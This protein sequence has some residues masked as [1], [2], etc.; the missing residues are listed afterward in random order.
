MQPISIIIKVFGLMAGLLLSL[1]P[2]FS[3]FPVQAE[4]LEIPGTGACEVLL[5]AVAQAFTAKY[6]GHQVLIPPSTGT[7]GGIRAVKQDRAVLGRVAQPSQ[8]DQTT[9]G[10][11]YLVFAQDMVIFAVG[12]KV[13]VRNLT[14]AQLV[15]VYTGKITDWREVGGEPGPIRVLARQPGDS[16]LKIIEENLPLFRKIVYTSSAKVAHTDPKMLEMLQKYKYSIGWLTFSG[17]K[18]VQTPL[19]PLALDG[20][21]P[22]PENVRSHKYKLVGPY[23]LVFKE[24]RLNNLAKLFID[25]I[26]SKECQQLMEQYGVV[27]VKK[28]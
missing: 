7:A 17:L 24:E 6:P 4:V 5:Q 22:T 28:E 10:L 14:S 27:P 15:D 16:N 23:A 1:G 13:T 20:I 8:G 3:P 21:A 11:R 12:G 9:E 19:Y 25:F 18:G 2:L 26:F